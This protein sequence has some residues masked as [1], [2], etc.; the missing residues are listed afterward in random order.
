MEDTYAF[1]WTPGPDPAPAGS[2]PG[3]AATILRGTRAGSGGSAAPTPLAAPA[4]TGPAGSPSS[5]SSVASLCSP[6]SASQ[7]RERVVEGNKERVV[8]L[9]NHRDRQTGRQK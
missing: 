9:E 3:V 2:R 7:Q 5:F 4:E 6:N 8:E 1:P